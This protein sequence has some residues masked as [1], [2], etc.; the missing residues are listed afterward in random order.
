[1]M[2]T[3]KIRQVKIILVVTAII[4]AVASLVISHILIKDLSNEE[5]NKMVTWAQ[6]LNTLNNAT[7]NTD[8][9]LVL[10]VI[11]SNNTIPV[12]VMSSKG[13]ICDYRNIDINENNA[14][15]S[16]KA[17]KKYAQSYYHSG[18]YIKIDLDGTTDYQLVCYDESIMLKR[19][20]TYPCVQLGI[21]LI[22]VVIAIF[23]L[24]SSKKAEQN[25]VWVGLSK[26]TAHQLGTPISSL[27]AWTE[28]LKESYP[29]DEMIRE[30]EKDVKRLEII[31]ERFSK[32]GSIPEPKETSLNEVITHVVEYMDRRTSS[33]VKI[34][35]NCGNT[36]I[37]VRINISLFEWVIE[38]LCKNAVDAMEGKGNIDIYTYKEKEK[39]IIEVKD[40]GKGI[41]RSD[42]KN[43]FTPGFTTKKRGWGL[44]LSLAKRIIEEYHKGKI[45]VKDSEIGKGTTFRIEL[46]T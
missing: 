21:V 46:P 7:E 1:M 11:K 9:T 8:L 23:A 16:I 29:E 25:K 19:L 3:D 20:A 39:T 12:I 35:S 5:H 4:I 43:V 17:L 2:W 36:N 34:T 26:E 18:K 33:K 38:N 27:L 42:I 10:N 15:D 22:F 44:G 41:K 28:I 45:Y 13:E 6:A 32:I 14:N 40:N 30:M 37:I 24:L 31:G